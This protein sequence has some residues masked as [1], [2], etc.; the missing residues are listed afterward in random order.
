MPPVGRLFLAIKPS[1][2]AAVV[3][4]PVGLGKPV[5]RALVIMLLA[6]AASVAIIGLR[7]LGWLIGPVFLALV[8]VILVNPLHRTLRRRG[9]PKIGHCCCFCRPFTGFSLG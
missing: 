7:Q 6:A 8:I 3:S 9:A 4:E 2:E 1:R 5:P